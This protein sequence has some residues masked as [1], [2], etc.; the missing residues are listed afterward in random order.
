M[1]N[2]TTALTTRPVQTGREL[3]IELSA[4][5]EFREQRR[6]PLIV[7]I[8]AFFAVAHTSKPTY[9]LNTANKRSSVQ[10]P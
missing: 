9:A 1:P 6:P 4:N 5:A 8:K 3:F 10:T 7:K 2:N